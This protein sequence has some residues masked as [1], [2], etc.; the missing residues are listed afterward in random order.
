M[1]GLRKPDDAVGHR[2]YGV[3]L[4]LFLVLPEQE[5]RDLPGRQLERETLNELLER[6][7]GGAL[8]APVRAADR[9]KRVDDDDLRSLALDLARDPLQDLGQVPLHDLGTE[10]DEL[11]GGTGEL[12]I[13]EAKL[14][15]VAEHL[16]GRLAEYREIQRRSLDGGIREHDL[17]GQRRLSRARAAGD[18]VEREFREP[19][20]EHDVEAGHSAGNTPDD[21]SFCLRHDSSRLT[22]VLVLPRSDAA[23]PRSISFVAMSAPTSRPSNS[24]RRISIT[25]K[26]SAVSGSPFAAMVSGTPWT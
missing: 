12:R 20:S 14:A 4:F 9:S 5:G 7:G 16:Q 6:E 13:E 23:N 25:S 2:E 24:T 21:R 22:S 8:R 1:R 11:D 19:T 15:L 17:V 10:I 26:A 3:P 18:Q